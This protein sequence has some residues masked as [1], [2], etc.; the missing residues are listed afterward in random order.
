MG[1]PQCGFSKAVEAV[2]GHADV[3][4]VQHE[5][6]VEDVLVLLHPVQHGGRPRVETLLPVVVVREAVRGKRAAEHPR[7]G[8]RRQQRQSRRQAPEAHV[9]PAQRAVAF[10]DARDE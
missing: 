6:L 1:Y 10:V 7:N 4:P 2:D 3:Q 5:V 8:H 9:P